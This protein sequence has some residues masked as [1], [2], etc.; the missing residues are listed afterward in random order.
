MRN[1]CLFIFLIGLS[2]CSDRT[3]DHAEIPIQTVKKSIIMFTDSKRFES[4]LIDD[5]DSISYDN[6]EKKSGNFYFD[7][8][9]FGFHFYQ[10]MA[11]SSHIN[12]PIDTLAR[13]SY[14]TANLHFIEE[15]YPRSDSVFARREIALIDTT[16]VPYDSAYAYFFWFTTNC[17]RDYTQQQKASW[18]LATNRLFEQLRTKIVIRPHQTS[19]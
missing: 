13:I 10:M 4:L 1:I 7:S 17:R 15:T 3:E 16:V 9:S 19:E 14:P 12:G 8:V 5:L 6:S 11:L 18:E 2:N